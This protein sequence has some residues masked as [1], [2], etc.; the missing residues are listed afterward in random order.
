[1]LGR[2]PRHGS[3][4]PPRARRGVR[5]PTPAKGALIPGGLT[6]DVD[7]HRLAAVPDSWLIRTI[8]ST[9]ALAKILRPMKRRVPRGFWRLLD[10]LGVQKNPATPFENLA[11][12]CSRSL[13]ICGPTEAEIYERRGAWVLRRLN[14]RENFTFRSVPEVDHLLLTHAARQ[15]VVGNLE[16][17]SCL[18]Y[19]DVSA[20]M[21]SRSRR[22]KP[23]LI[24]RRLWLLVNLRLRLIEPHRSYLFEFG[25]LERSVS[26]LEHFSTASQAGY[27]PRHRG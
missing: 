15:A 2:L 25:H 11:E 17:N 4:H 22:S 6:S 10:K 27:S 8:R 12:R 23:S 13:V 18:T 24:S 19:F 7:T 16:L 14:A 9:T 26:S 21:Q 1:M 5:D 20:R 3:G